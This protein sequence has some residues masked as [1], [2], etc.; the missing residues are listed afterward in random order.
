MQIISH[1]GLW[2]NSNEKNGL[3][4]FERSFNL[5]FG[6]ETD[7]RDLNG[8]LVISHDMP[9][10]KTNGLIKVE[11]FFDLYKSINDKL[12]LALNIKSDGL[13]EKLELLLNKYNISN[14]FFF[15]MS[16]PDTLS[17]FRKELNVFLRQSEYE[18]EVSLYDKTQ[19]IWLDCFESIWYSHELI[20]NHLNNGKIVCLVSEEL[21]NRPKEKLWELIKIWK[22]NRN[23]QII[24]CTD[25]PE[26]ANQYF[27]YE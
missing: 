4:S 5:S 14:Y 16:I 24:L 6:T 2:K 7:I 21:H 25:Y 19:G 10:N 8:E 15:D 3:E 11:D 12:F 27:N 26:L 22:L 1:R 23:D 13:Q 9:N 17:Y 18:K 20:E